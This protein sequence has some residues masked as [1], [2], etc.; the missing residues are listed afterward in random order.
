[1][2]QQRI[3]IIGV[4]LMGLGIASNVVKAGWQLSYLDHPG[5][6]ATDS[7]SQAGA[8]KLQSLSE[9]ADNS[10]VI[11]ICVTGS[12]EVESILTGPDGLLNSVQAETCI[13]DCSTAVPSST[14]KLAALAA[15]NGAHFLDAPMTRTPKEAAQG[16][17]NL[18]VGGA[19]LIYEQQLPLLQTFAENITHVGP[20]GSGHAMK[21]IHN[22]VSLGFSAILAEAVACSKRSDIDPS[23]LNRVLATGGGSGVVLDRMAP[24]FLGGDLESFAFT[25]ANSLKDISYYNSMCNDLEAGTTLAEAVQTLYKKPV[26]LGEGD[27]F[28]P[29]LIDMLSGADGQS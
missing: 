19:A 11:I 5:N 1:M 26:D 16:R 10:D 23:I 7:L 28:V 4:G 27:K 25:L 9:I 6:Q 20:V 8:Q 22:F 3:G 17:L 12:T 24:F 21:L 18:I 15:A 29:Q 14:R 2:P 13:I